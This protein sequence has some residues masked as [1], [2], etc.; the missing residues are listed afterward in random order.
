MSVTF[1]TAKHNKQFVMGTKRKFESGQAK[2]RENLFLP[3]FFWY[4]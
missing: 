2:V 4:H 1:V 3:I